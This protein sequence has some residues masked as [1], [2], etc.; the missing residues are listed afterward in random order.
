MQECELLFKILVSVILDI[1]PK[2]GLLGHMVI[3]FLIFLGN[4]TL[5][6]ITAAP[7][8]IPKRVHKD[9]NFSASSPTLGTF[10]VFFFL[11]EAILMFLWI[12]IMLQ[13]I[14]FHTLDNSDDENFFHLSAICRCW[15]D[16]YS[17]PLPIF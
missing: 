1:Y 17:I 2:G 7:F 10:S 16:V 3:L 6:Y 12:G 8:Y 4:A 9:Y 13:F 15:R 14:Y 11:I 5:F